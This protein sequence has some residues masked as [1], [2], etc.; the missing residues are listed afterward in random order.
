MIRLSGESDFIRAKIEVEANNE[1]I[2]HCTF[3]G[4]SFVGNLFFKIYDRFLFDLGFV[5]FDEY[6]YRIYIQEL[7]SKSI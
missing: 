1:R 6:P 5:P 7:L 3:D 2:A 4:Y